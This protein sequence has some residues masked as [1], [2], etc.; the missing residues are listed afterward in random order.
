MNAGPRR[1]RLDNVRFAAQHLR[2]ARLDGFGVFLADLAREVEEH[3][4]VAELRSEQG[5][6]EVGQFVIARRSFGK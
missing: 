5:L 1:L 6:I 2:P 4:V 3:A